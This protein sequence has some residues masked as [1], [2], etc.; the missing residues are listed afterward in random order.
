M[1]ITLRALAL[2]LL[3]FSSTANSSNTLL[4]NRPADNP[5]SRYVIELMT[6]VYKEL[7]YSLKVIDFN[8]QSA[9]VAA[10]EGVLDGQ[11]G[12]VNS[13]TEQYPALMQISFPIMHANLQLLSYCKTCSMFESESIVIISSYVAPEAYLKAQN[14]QGEIIKVKSSS[15][16]LNLLIQKKVSAALVVE[17]HVKKYREKLQ[18]LDITSKTLHKINIYH[19]LHKKHAKLI[20]QINHILGTMAK[21]G[22]IAML[23]QKYGI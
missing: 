17:F 19:Y 10:N 23:K 8:H 13:V 12:R 2:C 7:G 15:A 5:Q 20:P 1:N 21:E 18:S 22:T 11:L 4:F 9:L 3:I 16:Q 14:Y 6:L